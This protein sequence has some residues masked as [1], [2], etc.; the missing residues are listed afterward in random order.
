MFIFI[1]VLIF[2]AVAIGVCASAAF[3]NNTKMKKLKNWWREEGKEIFTPKMIL[4]G[5][6]VVIITATY[7]LSLRCFK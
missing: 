1:L 3:S 6:I 7:F 4:Y 2:V 5:I